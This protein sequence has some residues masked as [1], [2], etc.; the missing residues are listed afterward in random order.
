MKKSLLLIAAFTFVSHVVV[1]EEKTKEE[2]AAISHHT[3]VLNHYKDGSAQVAAAH[4]NHFAPEK[5][6]ESEKQAILFSD[7]L[8]NSSKNAVKKVSTNARPA[9]RGLKPTLTQIVSEKPSQ[10]SS[11]HIQTHATNVHTKTAPLAH[12][13]AVVQPLSAE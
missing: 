8:V 9:E 7:K 3:I 2:P 10:H 13:E 12:T 6:H 4:H 11:E 1:A 5:G